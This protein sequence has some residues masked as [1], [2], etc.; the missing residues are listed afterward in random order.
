VGA[1]LLALSGI[2]FYLTV[3]G[4]IVFWSL[5]VLYELI[6]KKRFIFVGAVMA[7]GVAV[8]L[9]CRFV[10]DIDMHPLR[11]QMKHEIGINP[12][13]SETYSVK[14]VYALY[15]FFPL[16]LI[17]NSLFA[18]KKK[19]PSP[20][21]GWISPSIQVLVLVAIS[22]ALLNPVYDPGKKRPLKIKTFAQKRQ[23]SQLLDYAEKDPFSRSMNI[24]DVHDI[25][26]ALYH[27]DALAETLFA[28][29]ISLRGLTLPDDIG[30][31]YNELFIRRSN[32]MIEM[33]CMGISEKFAYE[34]LVNIGDQARV[35]ENLAIINMV[36]GD[37]QTARVFLGVLAED[38][39]HSGRGRYWL[40]ILAEDP[41][42]S[43]NERITY[44]RSLVLGEKDGGV[45]L[46]FSYDQLLKRNPKNKAALEF[47]M[48][49]MLITGDLDRFAWNLN[50]Y[51]TSDSDKL[52]RSYD[53]ALALYRL[54]GGKVECRWEPTAESYEQG[55]RFL[56]IA[57]RYGTNR[58]GLHHATR[59]EFGDSYYFY[60]FI[61]TPRQK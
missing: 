37:T 59:Q 52:P 33:G 28:W 20:K 60:F 4:C 53:Q 29:P 32:M 2:L 56:G 11:W 19:V 5:V 13:K 27:T 48:S 39:I 7:F 40:D 51:V 50:R 22:V 10:F 30:G 16:L 17:V 35:L 44:L 6:L 42:L 21:H 18:G 46:A 14:A 12:I 25:V 55:R 15:F 36:K 45:N 31:Y 47:M 58:K 8:Y 57:K 24:L 61:H 38:L 54:T 23:W 43:G 49:Q 9:A 34:S 41:S 26:V 3:N 1:L